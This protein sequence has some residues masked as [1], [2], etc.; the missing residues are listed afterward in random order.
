[1]GRVYYFAYSQHLDPGDLQRLRIPVLGPALET[2]A[3]SRLA[4]AMYLTMNTGMDVRR[5][6]RLSLA[7]TNHARYIEYLHGQLRELP[8][9]SAIRLPIIRFLPPPNITGVM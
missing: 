9:C 8:N 1:M 7:S 6:M 4:W 3:L 2:L 5:A